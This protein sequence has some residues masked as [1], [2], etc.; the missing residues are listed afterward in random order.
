M[1]ALSKILGQIVVPLVTPFKNEGDLNYEAAGKL[2]DH[3]VGK[4]YCD[5]ILVAGTTARAAI[6]QLLLAVI[7]I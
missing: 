5:S 2:V 4:K 1:E 6:M 3:L 7:E